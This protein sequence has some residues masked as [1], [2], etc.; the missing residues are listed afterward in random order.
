MTDRM[1]IAGEL[2]ESTAGRV[3]ADLARRGIE[4]A[5]PITILVEPDDWLTQARVEMR[6]RVEA[7]GLTDDDI[8]RLIKDARRQANDEM[9]R[10]AAPPRS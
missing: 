8:D 10:E 3:A 9:R 2:I 7:A 1:R 4:P 6:H 5:R